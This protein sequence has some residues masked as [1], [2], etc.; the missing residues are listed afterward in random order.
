[1]PLIYT[2]IKNSGVPGFTAWRWAF[3][4]PGSMFVLLAMMTLLFS[5]DAPNGSYRDIR[6]SR[7]A[8]VD[9]K[10]TFLAGIRNYR[11][12]VRAVRAWK[13]RRGGG[14]LLEC[15]SSLCNWAAAHLPMKCAPL[16]L[17]T[18]L[19]NRLAGGGVPYTSRQ[20][21]CHPS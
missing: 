5:Q 14:G 19:F 2:G 8:P 11:C 9:G 13:V 10:K 16:H 20:L 6:K 7:A 17:C 15:L 1:M 12:A 21:A 4:V 18:H 3:M